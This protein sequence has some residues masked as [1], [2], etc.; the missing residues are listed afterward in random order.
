MSSPRMGKVKG[1]Y[2]KRI[3]KI[4]HYP[5]LLFSGS[6]PPIFTSKMAHK[7]KI[8]KVEGNNNT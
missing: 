1:G 2:Q 6:S 5:Y 3:E 7:D 4:E 8:I